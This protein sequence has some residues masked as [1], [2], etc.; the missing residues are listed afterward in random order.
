MTQPATARS[1]APRVAPLRRSGGTPAAGDCFGDPH[2]G[3]AVRE[4][5]A[6]GLRVTAAP[7][8]GSR[9]FDVLAGHARLRWFVVPT[10]PRAVRVASL[11]LIQPL[12]PAARLLKQ[13]MAVTAALGLPHFWRQ[14]RVHVSGTQHAARGFDAAATHAAFL[15]GTA[16]PHRK[17]TAQW[18]DARGGIRGYAKVS[19]TPAAQAL[20]DNEAAMLERLH[21][22]GL[23]SAIVPRVWLREFREDGAA[24]L[25]TDTVRTPRQPCCTRLHAS[26]L[27]FLAEL[28]ARTASPG[29]PDGEGLLRDLRARLA[30]LPPTLTQ[31]WRQRFDLALRELAFA[32]DLIAPQ[33]LAHG[34]FTPTNTFRCDGRLCVFDWEYAGYAYP[35]DYDLIRFLLALRGVRR[36]NPVDDCHVVE[37]ILVRDFRRA[38]A[39]ARARLTAYLC[40]QALMLAGRRAD[41]A[42]APLSWEGE[43]AASLMLDA[44]TLDGAGARG[45]CPR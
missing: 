9:P 10:E 1:P 17:L 37:S 16:S 18:M 38:P 14:G 11:A 44:L 6:L 28:V 20:L 32:P 29:M 8:P 34:D 2:F 22:I 3:A 12:R 19:R 4:M 41:S 42:G 35:A 21:R 15:T 45:R 39:A 13:A 27:A 25:A 26:H 40:V 24:I 23:H 36:R 43:H 30:Q 33:G 5:E 7:H 31:A